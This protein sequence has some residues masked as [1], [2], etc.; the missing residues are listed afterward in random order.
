M[1]QSPRF[2]NFPTF[3]FCLVLVPILCT[4]FIFM[5]VRLAG[6]HIRGPSD[7]GVSNWL[8]C[9]SLDDLLSEKFPDF[10]LSLFN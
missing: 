2:D 1:T 4:Y 5:P 9:L 10:Y 8:F 7:L 6:I 3:S